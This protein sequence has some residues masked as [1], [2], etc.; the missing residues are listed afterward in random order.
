[1]VLYTANS[2]TCD[3]DLKNN[4]ICYRKKGMQKSTFFFSEITLYI[5]QSLVA[6][7]KGHFM[8]LIIILCIEMYW[9]WRRHSLPIDI[10]SPTFF[11]YAT[12]MA[13]FYVENVHNIFWSTHTLSIIRYI[14]YYTFKRKL[15]HLYNT[16]FFVSKVRCSS[17]YSS[18][19][20]NNRV[21]AK[22]FFLI[23]LHMKQLF[24]NKA[25]ESGTFHSAQN[26]F[27]CLLFTLC[28]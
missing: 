13:W 10:S 7:Y 15:D 11:L 2:P 3:S 20:E 16:F 8:H 26:L 5:S 12:D 9:W 17:F 23:Q 28:L 22:H 14:Q 1:M 21:S 18:V 27:H 24:K 25:K 19:P 4:N 6:V